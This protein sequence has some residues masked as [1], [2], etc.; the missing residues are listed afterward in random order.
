MLIYFTRVLTFP[1]E[2][3]LR[4]RRIK[5]FISYRNIYF[6]KR[7]AI[8]IIIITFPKR[9]VNFIRCH[10]GY[11]NS[12]QWTFSS[13]SARTRRL[14]YY[15]LE[16]RFHFHFFGWFLLRL[17]FR[18]V[19]INLLTFAAIFL[20]ILLKFQGQQCIFWPR[21]FHLIFIVNANSFRTICSQTYLSKFS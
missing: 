12:K 9:K 6:N 13:K 3:S 17:I 5:S 7:K 20:W 11:C 10:Y 19:F 1:I 18:Y 2:S 21:K 4:S 16:I 15:Y 8:I 14:N